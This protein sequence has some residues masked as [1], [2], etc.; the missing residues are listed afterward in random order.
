MHSC[1]ALNR[2]NV[3]GCLRLDMRL[4]VRSETE[5][6]IGEVLY[7]RH[8][9]LHRQYDLH[10]HVLSLMHQLAINDD[11]MHANAVMHSICG[12]CGGSDL[13]FSPLAICRYQFTLQCALLELLVDA[14]VLDTPFTLD[15]W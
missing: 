1:N 2:Q 8:Y 4:K 15:K 5:R 6:L 11:L 3:H 7:A 12:V 14:L 13:D 10:A 9:S